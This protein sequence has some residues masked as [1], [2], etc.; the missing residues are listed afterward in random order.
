MTDQEVNAVVMPQAVRVPARLDYR[1][2]DE[3]EDALLPLDDMG[4]DS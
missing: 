1:K 4:G 2:L 3:L